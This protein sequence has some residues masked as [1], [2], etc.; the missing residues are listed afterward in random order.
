MARYC[1]DPLQQRSLME[2]TGMG[3]EVDPNTGEIVAGHIQGAQG[4][5]AT[6]GAKSNPLEPLLQ[7]RR[8]I[9]AN[10]GKEQGESVKLVVC[11]RCKGAAYCGQICQRAHWKA[12]HKQVCVKLNVV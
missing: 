1:P 3:V 10:C 6:T 5:P 7:T 4:Q 12:G 2:A 11:A 8:K 9:C